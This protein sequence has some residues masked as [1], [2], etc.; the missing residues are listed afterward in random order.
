MSREVAD[1]ARRP[2]RAASCSVAARRPVIVTARGG[3]VVASAL[4][5]SLL[6]R[7]FGADLD[8]DWLAS[9]LRTIEGSTGVLSIARIVVQ[10]ELRRDEKRREEK[11]RRGEPGREEKRREETN[12]SMRR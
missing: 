7:S 3:P 11:R 8:T 9:H 2:A 1:V 6:S 12:R 5:A 10:N 4:S